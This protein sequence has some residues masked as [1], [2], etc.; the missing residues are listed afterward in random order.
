MPGHEGIWGAVTVG[1]P[2]LFRKQKLVGS[3][4]LKKP[5]PRNYFIA[6]CWGKDMIQGHDRWD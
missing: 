5:L 3:D 2:G 4:A 6:I 1:F